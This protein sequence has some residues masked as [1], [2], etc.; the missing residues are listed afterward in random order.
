MA[1]KQ[2]GPWICKMKQAEGVLPDANGIN[3][4]SAVMQNKLR[5]WLL[6]DT[7]AFTRGVSTDAYRE[8][9]NKVKA[10]TGLD[11]QLTPNPQLQAAAFTTIRQLIERGFGF[12]TYE[13]KWKLLVESANK[14]LH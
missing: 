10:A 11:I 3:R 6:G 13:G 8:A 5:L 1:K 7:L 14:N 2:L 9:R 4:L 12:K